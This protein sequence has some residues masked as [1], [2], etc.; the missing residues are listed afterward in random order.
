[1]G[2]HGRLELRYTR[3]GEHTRAH[4][5]HQGPL[6]VLKAL[7]PEGP[8]LC[9]HVIVHPPAGL[10]GG[11]RLELALQLEPHAQALLSTP[12]ATRCYRSEGLP[13]HQEVR[14]RLEEGSRL[15]WLPQELIVYRGALA[16]NS[17]NFD[18]QAGAQMI[19]WDMVALGLPESGQPFSEGAI[20]QRLCVHT[21][22]AHWLDRARADA[23]DAVLLNSPLGLAGHRVW[24]T[25]WWACGTVP[26]A[27]DTESALEDARQALAASPLAAL[28]G[29]SALQPGLVVL[30]V[31]APGVEPLAQLLRDVRQRWRMRLWRAHAG[32]QR[33]WAT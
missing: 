11:D 21:P 17:L 1:M 5:S 25:L 16:H 31:L 19:G 3:A 10:V 27:A 2:W 6:R 20:T 12:G 32:V 4:F 15:E 33:L 26:A 9:Q 23:S 29:V 7:Y 18:L 8:Q 30:R 24:G 13:V 22:Q 28:G 14:A